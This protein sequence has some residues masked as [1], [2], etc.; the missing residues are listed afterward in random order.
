MAKTNLTTNSNYYKEQ[1]SQI[2]ELIFE[3]S[4]RRADER[5]ADTIE[6]LFELEAWT[7][8]VWNCR[9]AVE[10][11][12]PVMLEKADNCGTIAK[13]I[14]L[15]LPKSLQPNSAAADLRANGALS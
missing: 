1:S 5:A 7:Q 14:T 11:V 6:L 10:L 15:A 3:G 4:Q 8:V 9:E 13:A 12:L 2:V